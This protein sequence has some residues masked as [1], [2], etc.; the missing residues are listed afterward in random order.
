MALIASIDGATRRVFLDATTVGTSI[1]PI[2]IY[3][4]MRDLRRTDESLRKWDLF[5]SAS[6]NISKGGGKFTER[7]VT[8]LSGTRIVPFDTSQELTITGTVITD[9]GQEG[10][11]AFDRSSLN[12]NTVV[13][14]NYVP[15]QV[16]IITIAGGS[17]LD[18]GQDAKLTTIEALT[19]E[20]HKLQG[21]LSGS[22]M[23]V[24]DTARTVGGITLDI[25]TN[26]N[27]S[28]TVDRQ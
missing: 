5:M 13:D 4:E 14:I 16:E 21:L 10:I 1:H 15:P 19:A 23:T 11:A 3:K 18:A 24:S 9:D 27:G 22:P 26:G 7:L 12:V 2:D 8:L 17:G 25:T 6:G 28:V 20:I